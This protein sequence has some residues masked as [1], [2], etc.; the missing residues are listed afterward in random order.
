MKRAKKILIFILFILL[1]VGCNEKEKYEINK[2][3][4]LHGKIVVTE[5]NK[6]GKKEYV[7]VLELEKAITIDG[8]TTDKIELEYDK[9]LKNDTETT[10][11]GTIEVNDGKTDLKYRMNVNSVDNVL[12]YVNTF[13]NERFSLAI[14]ANLMKEVTVQKIQN[15]FIICSSSKKEAFRFVALDNSEYK[16][17]NK[18][19][20]D[21]EVVKSNK[22]TTVIVIFSDEEDPTADALYKELATIK[23]SV[24]LK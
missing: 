21:F 9:D 1:L 8:V 10:I 14:P 20:L 13:S 18:N 19:E 16:S 7:S 22:K 6:D 24:K 4:S 15:G 17:L 11:S 23:K 5:I 12:S 3:T 2:P